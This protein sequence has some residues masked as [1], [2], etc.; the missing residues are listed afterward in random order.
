[1]SYVCRHLFLTKSPLLNVQDSIN[2]Y[3]KISDFPPCLNGYKAELEQLSG[4]LDVIVNMGSKVPDRL[5]MAA[6]GFVASTPLSGGHTILLG[7]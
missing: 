2:N 6:N 3:G 5:F 1:M 7:S 4:S